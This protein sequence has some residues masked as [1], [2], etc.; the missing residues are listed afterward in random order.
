MTTL[1]RIMKYMIMKK[2]RSKLHRNWPNSTGDSV[3]QTLRTGPL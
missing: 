1:N 3:S 2:M